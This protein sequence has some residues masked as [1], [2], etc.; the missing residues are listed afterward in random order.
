MIVKKESLT[1]TPLTIDLTEHHGGVYTLMGIAYQLAKR[2]YSQYNRTGDEICT[3][4][5]SSDYEHAVAVMEKEFG[6]SIILIR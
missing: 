6:D 2:G 1:E 4:M 3:D 5:M